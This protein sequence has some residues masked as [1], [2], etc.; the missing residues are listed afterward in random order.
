MVPAPAIIGVVNHLVVPA[1]YIYNCTMDIYLGI[2]EY[3]DDTNNLN[4]TGIIETEN[5]TPTN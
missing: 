5:P 4:N 2:L 1:Y 3:K